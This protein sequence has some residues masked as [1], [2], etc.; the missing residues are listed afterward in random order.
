MADSN[1]R[2]TSQ[3]SAALYGIANWGADYF[4]VSPAGRIQVHA[5]GLEGPS[6]DLLGLVEE[7]QHRGLHTPLLVR[8]TDILASRVKQMFDD[9]AHAFS[10]YSYRGRYRGVYPI[11]V[12]QQRQ[13]VEELIE[14][15]APFGLGLEVGSKAELLV[16]LGILDNPDCLIVCNGYKD[17]AYFEMALLAQRLGR[18]P[19]IVLDRPTEVDVL[20]KAARE[21]GIQPHIGVR[22]RLAARGEGKWVESSG[23]RAKFGLSASEIVQTVQ[24]LRSEDMLDCLEMLHFHIGSQIT[25]IRA[26]KD[27]LR[28]A[29]RIFVGLWDL[30]AKPKFLDVGGGLAIDY[31]GSRTNFHSSMNYT[32]REYAMDVVAAIAE[33]CNELDIP[34]PDIVTESGRALVSAASILVFDVLGVDEVPRR[35]R[36]SPP[37]EDDHRVIQELYETWKNVS[38]ENALESYHD[39]T[40]LKEEGQSLFALGYIDLSTR[41]RFEELY[42]SC[43]DRILQVVRGMNYVPEDLQGLERLLSDT[44]YGNFSI[45]QSLPDS[46][47]VNQLFPVMPIHRLDEKPTRRGTFAD[48]TCDSDGKVDRFIDLHDVRNVLELHAPDGHPYYIGVFMVGAY[49]ETLGELHNLFGDTD[50]VHVRIQRSGHY[51]IE[52]VVEGDSMGEVLAYVQ[53][54][55]RT[56]SERVRRAIE[57]ALQRGDITL[58][59]SAR[60]RRRYE[61]GL[62]GYTYLDRPD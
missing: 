46:W 8:F 13:V 17:R 24:R 31:D 49:Q 38:A 21:L 56:L 37:Q 43:C 62:S 9:F 61:Q 53:Y 2:W 10:E 45:F 35:D 41:G 33:A 11:K 4:S 25:A 57:A 36:V 59:E 19:I 26:H 29:S 14:I 47:S 15:G 44:Y 58:E 51:Q 54:D 6:V 42:W 48:L 34:H 40:Q 20:I 50:V 12:N 5:G 39:A 52:H 32:S 30:G 28:E 60:L 1:T 7:I 27:A 22:A 23:D 18:Y 16:A 3:H 55:R